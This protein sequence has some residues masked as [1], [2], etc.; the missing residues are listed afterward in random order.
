MVDD[1]TWKI[2]EI[3]V[4]FGPWYAGKAIRV[5]TEKISRISYDESTVYVN[6]A[7]DAVVPASE[8]DVAQAIG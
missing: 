6:L 4:E 2:R 5:P 8:K 3:V 7:K 1:R